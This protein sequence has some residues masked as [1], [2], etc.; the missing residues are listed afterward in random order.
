MRV[1]LSI[2][3]SIFLL[4][5][6]KPL[7]SQDGMSQAETTLKD[8]EAAFERGRPDYILARKAIEQAELTQD[9]RLKSRAYGLQAKLDSSG[10]RYSRALPNY[11]KSHELRLQADEADASA[12]LAAAEAKAKASESARSTAIASQTKSEEELVAAKA[13]ARWKY[14]TVIGICLAILAAGVLGFLA[15][16]KKLRDDVKAANEAQ[17]VSDQGFAKART[18]LTES[19]FA[20]LK[21][22]R[23]IFQSLAA[24]ISSDTTATTTMV[25][26]Q[27]AALGYLSQSSFDQGDTH[28]VAME[29]FFSKF[30]PDLTKLLSATSST[31]LNANSMPLRLPLDQ[32]VPVA[33]IY[34]ELVSNAFKHGGSQVET[35][36]TK[37]GSNI[38]LSV[39]DNGSGGLDAVTKA[40]GL[41]LVS[42]FSDAIK[43]RLDYPD[44]NTIR[45]RFSSSPQRALPGIG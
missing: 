37:E 25:A 32:A 11:L 44:S 14:L 5:S 20:S 34:T 40:E 31:K 26:A 12:A 22:L 39:T 4:L 2:L 38:S 15:T 23:R 6:P 17:E 9:L 3:F 29:A 10:R 8:A 45:L 30:N 43:G 24:R 19:S 1:F 36:L 18:E 41:K 7:F 28:E 27:N 16:V 33:L 21:Q 42:Y 13:A 35:N